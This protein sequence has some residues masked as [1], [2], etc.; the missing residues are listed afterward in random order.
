MRELIKGFVKL[1]AETLPIREPIVEFGSVQVP[2]QAGF[3]DLRPLFP[4]MKYVGADM[5]E[6]IGVDVKLN[7]HAVGLASGSVG[8]VLMLDTLEHVEYPYRA[9]EEAYR[10]LRPDGILI[11]SSVLNFIIHEYPQDYW[12][13]TPEAFKSLLKP[14]RSSLV[15][16]TGD[17]EFPHTVVGVGFKRPASNEV[18]R[19]LERRCNDWKACWSRPPGARWKRVIK[20]WVP[21]ILVD[22]Y[23]KIRGSVR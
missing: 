21:P 9:V 8:A 4:G 3:P 13:F 17:E 1:C 2:G 15:S 16:Y 18:M 14:F 10:I 6:G 20:R 12:R 11:M 19:E 7:L 23:G 5:R 22:L